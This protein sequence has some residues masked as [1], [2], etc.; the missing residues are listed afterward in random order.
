MPWGSKQEEPKSEGLKQ[1]S[2]ANG[3]S[4]SKKADAK[5]VEPAVSTEPIASSVFEFG[6]TVSMGKNVMRGI[7]TGEFVI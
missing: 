7:C 4:I 6:P 5:P 3:F 1:A 2:Q